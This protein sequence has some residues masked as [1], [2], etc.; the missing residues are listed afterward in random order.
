[1]SSAP[2]FL[3]LSLHVQADLRK[4]KEVLVL[5]AGNIR[6]LPES[7]AQLLENF[8]VEMLMRP[9]SVPEVD[10]APPATPT[11][12]SQVH[13]SRNMDDPP[14]LHERV[15]RASRNGWGS[16]PI[17]PSSPLLSHP[18]WK[19]CCRS[20]CGTTTSPDGP[21]MQTRSTRPM[22]Q[23]WVGEGPWAVWGG[24]MGCRGRG[25]RL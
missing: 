17:L 13:V 24:A 2:P 21:G 10:P 6:H 25:H 3:S 19:V 20:G 18:R 4:T 9:K 16:S 12:M 14:G 15:G 11:G 7:S 5:L 23:G 1:M 8:R 22:L